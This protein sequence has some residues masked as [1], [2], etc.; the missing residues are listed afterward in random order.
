MS[1]AESDGLG[2]AGGPR[3]RWHSTSRPVLPT[4]CLSPARRF[5]RVGL[6]PAETGVF[7]VRFPL[8]AVLR[9]RFLF[10]A[11]LLEGVLVGMP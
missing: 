2:T 4:P 6:S 3:P 8:T 11:K 7:P 1:L 9:R 10:A 5:A